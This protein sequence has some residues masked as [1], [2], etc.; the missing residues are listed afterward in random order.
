MGAT[1]DSRDHWNAHVGYIFEELNAFV[2]DLA[3]NAR[4]GNV[5]EGRKINAGNELAT[6]SRQIMILLARSCAIRSKAST[7]SV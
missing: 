2:V 6:R 3:P 4:I 7:N 1:L 5:A